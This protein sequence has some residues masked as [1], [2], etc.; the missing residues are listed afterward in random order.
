MKIYVRKLTMMAVLVTMLLVLSASLVLAD[1]GIYHTIS[2]GETLFSIGR[3]YGVSPY[4]I[5]QTNSLANPNIIFAGEV[6][7]IPTDNAYPD[8]G[9][10]LNPNNGGTN[11]CYSS[12]YNYDYR[13]VYDGRQPN[14]GRGGWGQPNGGYGNGT[15]HTVVYGETLSSIALQY[16]VSPWAI[17]S[18]NGLYNIDYIYAGQVLSI[19][20]AP[21]YWRN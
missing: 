17:A 11:P 5:A 21:N 10:Y 12:C 2:R 7:Y 13:P 8:N 19:P 6:L 15:S 20:A 9:G 18:A 4:Y 1:G 3:Y 16:G 14:D